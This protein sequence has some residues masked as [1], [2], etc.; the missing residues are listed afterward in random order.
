MSVFIV[1]ELNF[2]S[3]NPIIGIYSPFNDKKLLSNFLKYPFLTL[4]ITFSIHFHALILWLKNIKIVRHTKSKYS[5]ISYNG[6][7]S[8]N[9][10]Y[11]R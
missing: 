5:K 10:K 1:S 6:K 11:K 8:Y 4:K 2:L 7:Y 3:L 9:E